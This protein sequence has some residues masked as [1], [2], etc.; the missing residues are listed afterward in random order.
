M[1]WDEGPSGPPHSDDAETALLAAL[2]QRNGILERLDFLQPEH[3]AREAHA[4]V[5]AAIRHL[6]EAGVGADQI[7]LRN[8]L[9]EEGSLSAVGGWP[10][11]VSLSQSVT[12]LLNA[13][14]YGRLIH[15]HAQRRRMISLSSGLGQMAYDTTIPVPEVFEAAESGLSEIT[16]GSSAKAEPKALAEASSG[17]LERRREV[18]RAGGQPIGLQTRLR[19]IDGPL[20]GLKGG[21]LIILA[22]RPSMGK[23]TAAKTVGFN[24]ASG[25]EPGA[26]FSLEE[27][28][29]EVIS[30][31]AAGIARIDTFRQE[32]GPL[33]EADME[34]LEE[35]EIELRRLPLYVDERP[36]LTTAQIRSAARKLKRTRG[37]KWIAVDHMGLCKPRDERRARYEQLGQISYDL[38][39]LAK[40]LDIPVV[41][42][43]QLSRAVEGRDDK[44]PTLS[45]LRESG[46]IEENADVVIF[47]FREQYYLERAEP[48]RK[49]NENDEKFS[50][51][52]SDWHKRMAACRDLAEFSFPKVRQGKTGVSKVAFVPSQSRFYDLAREGE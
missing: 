51:R 8:L 2:L 41:A 34:R 40:E 5:F 44:R 50:G 49:E 19:A 11:V 12:S 20:G 48:M 37:I 35:A 52:Q 21:R 4:T 16:A 3:F 13:E 33:T 15:D 14:D 32:N 29:D 9:E 18:F 43:C 36:G 24:M 27:G 46:N 17:W 26:Y 30:S 7:T 28:E 38:K 39:C 42:L 25:G 23:S 22:G 6:S 10:F 45:D 31:L 47:I 1:P